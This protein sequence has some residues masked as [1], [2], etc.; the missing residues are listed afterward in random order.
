MKFGRGGLEVSHL[1][2]VDDIILIAEANIQ[3]VNIIKS[4][5]DSFCRCSG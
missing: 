1:M 2:F 5:L 4:T 3:Q